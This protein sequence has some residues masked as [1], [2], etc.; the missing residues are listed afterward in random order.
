MEDSD[1]LDLLT[2]HKKMYHMSAYEVVK[3]PDIVLRN[4]GKFDKDKTMASHDFSRQINSSKRSDAPLFGL[5]ASK[6]VD[7]KKHDFL[8]VNQRIIETERILNKPLS[9]A[10][11]DKDLFSRRASMDNSIIPHE[12]TEFIDINININQPSSKN[13]TNRRMNSQ[14]YISPANSKRLKLDERILNDIDLATHENDFLHKIE[15]EN[16][17]QFKPEGK[18]SRMKMGNNS[19]FESKIDG[20]HEDGGCQNT[21]LITIP[22]MLKKE[23]DAKSKILLDL[24]KNPQKKPEG[25]RKLV[26]SCFKS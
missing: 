15:N 11:R 12:N 19:S 25:I 5:Y 21:S 22:D 7:T 26:D 14:E 16:K 18:Q 4:K 9:P 10:K 23:N 20:P 1:I 13:K 2:N 24:Y 8:K 17:S 3:E 6:G